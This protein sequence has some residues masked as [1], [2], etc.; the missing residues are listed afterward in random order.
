MNV[1][2]I[3]K[4]EALSKE[5]LKRMP[6]PEFLKTNYWRSVADQVKKRDGY[7]CVVCNSPKDIAAHHRTYQHHGE[8]HL[9]MSDLTTLCEPCHSRHHFPPP[10][11]KERIVYVNQRPTFADKMKEQFLVDTAKTLKRKL[12]WVRK[13]E[14]RTLHQMLTAIHLGQKKGV[15]SNPPPIQRIVGDPSTVEA[16][17]PLGDPITLTKHI[18]DKCRANGAFTTATTKALGLKY[19]DM[20]QG[21]VDKLVGITIPRAQLHQAMMGRHIYAKATFKKKRKRAE[22]EANQTPPATP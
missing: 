7:R 12:K 17:M 14:I 4:P 10:P 11:P 3:F 13:Q 22:R 20:T 16:D 15:N 9:F 5:E 21:W 8:E 18:L 2:I 1:E 6:Y 19:A